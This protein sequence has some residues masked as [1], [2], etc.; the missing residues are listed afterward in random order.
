MEPRSLKSRY[1]LGNPLTKASM[2][3]SLPLPASGF[4]HSICG[5]KTPICL[6]A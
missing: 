1:Q 2:D 3:P 6:L 4:K 5:S